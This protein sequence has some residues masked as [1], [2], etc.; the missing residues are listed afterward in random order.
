[1]IFKIFPIL[2]FPWILSFK[3]NFVV[4]DK[5]FIIS[6][7]FIKFM[8]SEDIF[9]SL[10]NEI[11]Y[12][13][14]RSFQVLKMSKSERCENISKPLFR[15]A[16]KIHNDIN[17]YQKLIN[18]FDC[19]FL[20]A[21]FFILMVARIKKK[22]DNCSNRRRGLTSINHLCQTCDVWI[23]EM[24]IIVRHSCCSFW[25]FYFDVRFDFQNFDNDSYYLFRRLC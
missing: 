15:C 3:L 9:H 12:D 5:K 23:T 24:E 4:F 1:M 22:V 20:V 25:N 10:I 21:Y 19:A 16:L 6:H 14:K 8:W 2:W 18:R 11:I 17:R 13:L 7:P